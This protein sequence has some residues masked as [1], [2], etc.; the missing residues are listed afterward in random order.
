MVKEM[1]KRDWIRR[2]TFG[3]ILL[4]CSVVTGVMA[5]VLLVK[6]VG[7]DIKD[8]VMIGAFAATMLFGALLSGMLSYTL[9]VPRGKEDD[10]NRLVTGIVFPILGMIICASMQIVYGTDGQVIIPLVYYMQSVLIVSVSIVAI[11]NL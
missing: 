10:K 2:R 8:D 9:F 4:G 6:M 11:K 3:R 5:I 1:Q 7:F